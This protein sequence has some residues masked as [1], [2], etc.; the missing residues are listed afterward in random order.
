MA[1]VGLI[2]VSCVLVAPGLMAEI[3]VV[4]NKTVEEALNTPVTANGP[5][6]VDE[7]VEI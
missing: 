2:S 1:A 5:A 6:T 4:A 7:P 3:V